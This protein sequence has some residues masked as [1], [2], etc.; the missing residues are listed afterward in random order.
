MGVNID[1]VYQQVLTIANKNQVGGYIDSDE[2]NRYAE[3]S[4]REWFNE[5][6]M[7][8]STSQNSMDNIAPILVSSIKNI[9]SSGWVTKPTDYMHLISISP[10]YYESQTSSRLVDTEII[11]DSELASRR[12]TNAFAPSKEYPVALVRDSIIQIYPITTQGACEFIY[13]RQPTSPIWGYTVSN[14]EKVY[15]SS[16]STDFEVPEQHFQDL[17][18]RIVVNFGMEIRDPALISYQPDTSKP[19]Q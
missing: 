11:S 5:A 12:V 7:E 17:V 18:Q 9:D 6:Y 4:Q 2:F 15:D 10:R 3:I 16:S 13:L 19:I 14:N 8:F 1:K